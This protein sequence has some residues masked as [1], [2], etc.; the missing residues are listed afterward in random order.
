MYRSL[1]INL[2]PHIWSFNLLLKTIFK[3][4]LNTLDIISLLIFLLNTF[5][6]F[7]SRDAV[8]MS[9]LRSILS[10]FFKFS[11]SVDESKSI[12]PM[13]SFSP[14]VSHDARK[15][16]PTPFFFKL[17]TWNLYFKFNSYNI[18]SVSSVELLFTTTRSK[19]SPS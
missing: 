6:S 5:E 1:F 11:R 8:K 4:I 2:K 16:I 15:A 18:C 19:S 12:Y 9:Y 7:S 13:I 10:I 17:I 3:I 14:T